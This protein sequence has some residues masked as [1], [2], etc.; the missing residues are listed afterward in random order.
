MKRAS[1]DLPLPVEIDP[2]ADRRAPADD[3]FRGELHVASCLAWEML[4]DEDICGR[5]AV[6][7]AS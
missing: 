4:T 3:P 7:R 2:S 5:P 6:E 1:R